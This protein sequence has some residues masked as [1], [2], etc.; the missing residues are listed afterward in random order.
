VVQ[1]EKVTYLWKGAKSRS[2]SLTSFLWFG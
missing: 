1:S 2:S